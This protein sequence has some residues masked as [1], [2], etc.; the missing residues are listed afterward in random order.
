MRTILRRSRYYEPEA[1]T[2]I[3][4]LLTELHRTVADTT[5][6]ARTIVVDIAV[7]ARAI[8]GIALAAPRAIIVTVVAACGVVAGALAVIVDTAACAALLL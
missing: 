1:T 5:D 7:A 2:R 6:A 3:A 8:I 4:R